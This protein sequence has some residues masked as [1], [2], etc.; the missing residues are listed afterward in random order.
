MFKSHN[1]MG[2]YRCSQDSVTSF[3]ACA[4]RSHKHPLQ[5]ATKLA[6]YDSESLLRHT[7][8]VG[9]GQ[10]HLRRSHSS[11]RLQL[12]ARGSEHEMKT[13]VNGIISDGLTSDSS[14]AISS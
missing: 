8:A 3:I 11:F 4:T 2:T 12:A 14:E 13:F 7:N 6:A 5:Y 9:K 10:R 1:F